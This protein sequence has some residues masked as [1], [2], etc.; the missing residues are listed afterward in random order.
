[1]KRFHSKKK[2]RSNYILIIIISITS[3]LSIRYL[4]INNKINDDKIANFIVYNTLNNDFTNI[5]D[6][7]VLFKY[8]F[9]IKLDHNNY[10]KEDISVFKED[11]PIIYLYNTHQ[12]EK[13]QS[14]YLNAY[15]IKSGVLLA[16]KILKEYL[17][18]EGINAIVEER[19][20]TKELHNLNL[21]YGGSYKVSRMFMESA[22][23]DNNSLKYFIDLHRDSS[24]YSKTT[25]EI[26]GKK[27]ARLLFVIGLDNKNYEENLNMVL[28]LKEKIIK[29]NESLFRGIMK[30]QGKGVNGI[31]N[32]DFNKNVILIEVGGQYNNI[33]EVNNTLKVLAK[34]LGDY[35]KEKEND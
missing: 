19:S 33:D 10:E 24:K 6:V 1:M 9:N 27:Y 3:L 15:N 32:Q 20:I 23:K 34:I 5:S 14:S 2:T 30:K 13:Y 11:K 12:D 18:N 25:T 28:E 4:Y 7:D 31:Y 22:Y 26:D 8:A 21:S 35:V 17:S 16:S 29:Y